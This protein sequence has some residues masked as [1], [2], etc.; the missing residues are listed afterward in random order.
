MYFL[1]R[2][3]LDKFDVLRMCV[4]RVSISFPGERKKKEK[5]AAA[6]SQ[7]FPEPLAKK[8]TVLTGSQIARLPLDSLLEKLNE[9][10][11]Q[12]GAESLELELRALLARACHNASFLI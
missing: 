3:H 7:S 8:P 10:R 1:F 11:V 4:P 2:C 5:I 12:F 6:A 9:W